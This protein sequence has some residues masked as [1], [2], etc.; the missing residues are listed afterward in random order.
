MFNVI[1]NYNGIECS[2]HKIAEILKNPET[3]TVTVW[4][5]SNKLAEENGE[6][7]IN[8]TEFVFNTNEIDSKNLLQ[9]L[10]SKIQL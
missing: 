3:I 7:Y 10:I 5:Y 4:S 1:K 9:D 6:I 2:Y 8:S